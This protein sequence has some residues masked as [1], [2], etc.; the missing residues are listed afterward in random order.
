MV[1][2]MISTSGNWDWSRLPPLLPPD[3]RDQIAVVQPPQAWLG[4]NTPEWRWTENR[5]FTTSSAYSFLSDLDSNTT[6]P[7]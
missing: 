5:Q 7:I 4:S 2:D 3:I 1:A 6:N